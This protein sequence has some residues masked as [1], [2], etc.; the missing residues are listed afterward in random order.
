V[1]VLSGY[2]RGEYLYEQR[3]WLRRPDHI[4]E[5]LAAAAEWI[6]KEARSADGEARV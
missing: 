6:L 3:F 5:D 4:A 2:G 1:L